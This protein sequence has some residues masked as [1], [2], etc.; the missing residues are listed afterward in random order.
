MKKKKIMATTDEFVSICEKV[1]SG[2]H[3]KVVKMQHW[4]FTPF[5]KKVKDRCDHNGHFRKI[6][7]AT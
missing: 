3:T 6:F 4:Q 7:Y 2:T 1:D 5:E